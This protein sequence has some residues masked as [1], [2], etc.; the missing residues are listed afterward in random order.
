MRTRAVPWLLWDQ[1]Q[2]QT[3]GRPRFAVVLFK[4]FQDVLCGDLNQMYLTDLVL[5]KMSARA[6]T[7]A[8]LRLTRMNARARTHAHAFGCRDHRRYAAQFV[9]VHSDQYF[10][11]LVLLNP[12]YSARVS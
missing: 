1:T 7:H 6:R 5:L 12:H 8:H 11:P 9:F 3:L 2:Q 10:A 4:L